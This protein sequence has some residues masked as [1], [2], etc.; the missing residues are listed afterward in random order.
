MS[1]DVSL[2]KSA[3]DPAI[4]VGWH[5]VRFGDI[6]RNV[7]VRVDRKN[8]ELDKYVAGEHMETDDLHIKKW[9]T[10]GEDYL[11]PAFNQKFVKGQILYGSRRTY[12]RK[13][14]IADFDGICANTTFVIEQKGNDLIPNLIPFIMQSESFTQ[15]SIRMSKGSVN[16]Y[17]NWKDIASYK[18]LI[19][20]IPEQRDITKILMAAEECI[21]KNQR[22]LNASGILKKLLQKQLLTKGIRHKEF[23]D[24]PIGRLPNEWGVKRVSDVAEI[25]KEA[26]DP[27]K[28]LSDKEFLYFDI[29]SVE[30]GTG[31][32][33]NPRRI[34]GKN[35]PSRARRVIHENDVMMSTV[36]PYFK[37]F[38][39]VP[40]EYDGQICSTGFAVLRCKREIMPPYLL[41]S[42]FSDAVMHQCRRMMVGGQYPALN[43]SQVSKIRIP[44][45]SISEQGEIVQ[46]LSVVDKAT[47]KIRETIAAAKA[48]KLKLINKLLIKETAS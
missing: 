13:V 3:N 41:Y 26:V 14:A 32:I 46:I 6:V 34:L 42:L 2:E 23:K 17:V 35:A 9:G 37:A 8:C 21:I 38:A 5:K 1:N 39:L 28:E 29:D 15:H 40:P 44:L 30:S 31:I 4:P 33:G 25:N 16:P 22:L 19:P 45:P 27:T 18:F 20:P 12:L 11:G 10:I 24:T 7:R 47:R 43:S 48:L 36:R